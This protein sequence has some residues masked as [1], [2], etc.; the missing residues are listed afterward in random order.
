[1]VEYDAFDR[2]LADALR[3]YAAEAPTEVDALAI[4]HTIVA[5]QPGRSRWITIVGLPRQRSLLLSILLGALLVLASYVAL[6]AVGSW[7]ER[8]ELSP[9]SLV[10]VPDE[11]YGEWQ[12]EISDIGASVPAGQYWI[13]LGGAT[14]V[15]GSDGVGL[16]WLGRVIEV[17]PT[18][19]GTWEVVVRSSGPCGDGRYTLH[20]YEAPS[21]GDGV[22]EP[23]QLILTDEADDCLARVAILS[24]AISTWKRATTMLLVPGR[25]YGSLAFTEPFHFVA[26]PTDPV[27]SISEW[28]TRGGLQLGA[29][30]CWSSRIIDDQP[31][32][33]D[34]CDPTRG[35][36]PDVPATPVAVGEWLRSSSGL[37][38]S[39]PIEVSVDG[40]IALR[41]DI[42]SF[43]VGIS[44]SPGC[45]GASFRYYAIPTGDD[46]ILY[47][48]WS[49]PGSYPSVEQGVEALVR[50]ITFDDDGG[51]AP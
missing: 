6:F 9:D 38:V 30:C 21:D 27:P 34:V 18:G 23:E 4:A 26:P 29:G 45:P 1:M 25:S 24:G 32:D 36:L 8:D 19:P 20:G 50:S 7:L 43:D 13:D 16:D 3:D 12:A 49:D 44:N 35:Q 47:S 14:L 28:V 37:V 10:R 11:L 48:V 22:L 41:F 31:V 46:T 33:A 5:R 15:R 42:E 39:D 40:R 17:S 2:R 51:S